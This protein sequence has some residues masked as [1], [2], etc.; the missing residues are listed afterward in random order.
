MFELIALVECVICALL[1]VLPK[2]WAVALILLIWS[3]VLA[4]LSQ[5]TDG[6]GLL[7]FGL[8][9]GPVGLVML[10]LSVLRAGHVIV[11]SFSSRSYRPD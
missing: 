11:R 10:L 3:P 1:V 8:L 7:F 2:R 5:A 4:A 9:L 6:R